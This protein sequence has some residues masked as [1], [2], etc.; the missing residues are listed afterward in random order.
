MDWANIGTLSHYKHRIAEWI[1]TVFR[2]YLV[3][4]KSR[5]RNNENNNEAKPPASKNEE[6][7]ES[8][9]VYWN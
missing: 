9:M 8:Q 5:G 7:N 4:D 2:K 3:K 1:V 6:T